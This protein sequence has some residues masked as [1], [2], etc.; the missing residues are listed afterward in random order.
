MRSVDIL[1]QQDPVAKPFT[2]SL[3]LHGA[4]VAA[5]LVS[6][7][8]KQREVMLGS[9]THN[10]GTIGVNVVKTIPIPHREAPTNRVANDTDSNVPQAPEPKVAPKPVVKTK[11]P[12]PDAIPLPTREKTKPKRVERAAS[13]N[14][15]RPDEPYKKNQIFSQTQQAMSSPDYGIQGTNGIGVGPS[16]PFGQ[17]FGWYA[18]QIFDRVSQKWNRA[19]VTS[20]PHAH[21]IV[22][23]SLQRNGTVQNIQVVQSS[24]SYTLDT[25][26]QRAV[27]D[28]V[29]LPPFP[30]GFNYNAVNVDLTFE[31]QQ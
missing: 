17:Q 27:M 21:A 19:D 24:G 2:G 3:L 23:F 31:L 26:A 11:T 5:I 25:S 4:L 14:P 12:P 10:S 20:R 8:F 29:P 22:R 28:A 7:L 6:P 16:N 9:P 15:Y 13:S 1:D 18:Q 30:A